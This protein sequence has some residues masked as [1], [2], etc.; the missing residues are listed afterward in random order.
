MAGKGGSRPGA[1]RKTNKVKALA[2]G[3]VADFFDLPAQAKLWKS[4]L[5]SDDERIALEAGKYLTDRLY[6][7]APQSVDMTS[8]GESIAQV[9][10]NL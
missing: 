1:G 9:I 6:G 10:V 4:M 2:A 8:K 3:F 5:A 7:K